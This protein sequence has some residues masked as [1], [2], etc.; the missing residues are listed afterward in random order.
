MSRGI[1]IATIGGGSSYT[2][3]LVDGFIRRYNTLPVRELWLVDVPEGQWKMET[4]A[5]LAR[6]MVKA[7]GL[8]I[9]ICTTLNRSE[10]LDGAD[11]VTTQLR[12]GQLQARI[13]DER[14]PLSHGIL[15]QETNGAG[16]LF[17]G[18]RTIPVI[19]D[20][21]RDMQKLCP[22]AW[23]I[24]FTNPVGMVMEGIHRHTGFKKMI[25]LCNVPI[26]MHK[27]IA[28]LLGRSVSEVKVYFGG[29]NH[30]VFAKQVIVE[31]K[32]VTSDV[33]KLWGEQSVKNI[34]GI[35]WDPDFIKT[36]GVLPCSYHRYYYMA[37]EYLEEAVEKFKKHEVRAEFVKEVEDKLFEL[38]RDETL[39]EKPKL[40]E[41]RGGAYYSDAACSLIN[42]LYNDLGDI[43]VVN[44][45]NGGAIPNF[46]ADEIVE[47][48]AV[49]TKDGPKPVPVGE[50]P[51]AVNGLI[52]QIKA[53]EVMGC[54][55]AVS[56][57]RSKALTALMI[58][59]LVMSQK[60]ARIVLDELLEAHREYLPLFFKN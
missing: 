19:M 53:F 35:A 33:L 16:G 44:T 15:G 59:P 2:P 39:C 11:F 57:S 21:C 42:S 17:K 49:I 25:G 54:D 7:A 47:V 9:K 38:Y 50:L 37:K 52:Q 24:N 58:N 26:G 55:A 27:A 28:E 5:A 32:D 36:L 12:V 13:K 48:S 46:E 10:A 6:R 22:D 14:I 29:L 30:M 4:V 45:V 8:P 18:L 41:E 3:E 1:K 43:Q 23:L 56:G 60:T 51:K 20:I 40:L 34:T 31:G